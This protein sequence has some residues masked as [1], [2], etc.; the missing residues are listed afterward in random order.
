MSNNEYNREMRRRALQEKPGWGDLQ[1][2]LEA[3]TPEQCKQFIGILISNNEASGI[4]RA[5]SMYLDQA[6]GIAPPRSP[7]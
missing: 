5:A 4:L 2:R 7:W 1:Q 6:L 3:L